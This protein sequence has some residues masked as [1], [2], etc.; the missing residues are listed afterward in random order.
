MRGR[1]WIMNAAL[2][3][4][5]FGCR[6]YTY[7][8]P[9]ADGGQLATADLPPVYPRATITSPQIAEAAS[10]FNKWAG[11]LQVDGTPVFSRIEILPPVQTLEPYGIGTYQRALRLPVVLTTGTAWTTIPAE[12]R[13]Q[14]TAA[15]FTN[16]SE[17]LADAKSDPIISPTV[18]VQTPQGLELAWVNSVANGRRLLHGDSE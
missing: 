12:Q 10:Q 8:S 7:T 6:P 5:S 11:E 4:C 17:R 2:L 3:A 14:I 18:T 13:E 15:V 16:L 9:A 1:I